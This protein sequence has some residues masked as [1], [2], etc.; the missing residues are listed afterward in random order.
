MHT[1]V[2]WQ[3]LLLLLL[4][5]HDSQLHRML[6]LAFLSFV[7]FTH[8]DYMNIWICIPTKLLLA[9]W[10]LAITLRCGVSKHDDGAKKMCL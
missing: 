10:F 6:F 9:S 7:F 4:R 3:L 2:C 8:I 1:C 5:S